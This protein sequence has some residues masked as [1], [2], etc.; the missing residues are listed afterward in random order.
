MYMC[1]H[2]RR[3]LCGVYAESAPVSVPVRGWYGCAEERSMYPV[4]LSRM[5]V[6]E[7]VRVYRLW[8]RGVFCMFGR[9]NSRLSVANS[10]VY[11][12]MKV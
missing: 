5:H 10:I 7:R 6:G 1:E 3:C 2:A 8:S 9:T 12:G 11:Y 4:D